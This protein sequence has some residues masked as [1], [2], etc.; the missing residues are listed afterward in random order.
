MSHNFSPTPA[1]DSDIPAIDHLLDL[2]F[3]P[4]RRT[5]TSYRL[6]EGATAADGLSWVVRDD[7]LGVV[8]A[9][10]FWP[11]AIGAKGVPALLLGPLAVHPQRQNLGIGL[12]LM[13][14]ALGLA[15]SLGHK[16]VILVGDA[17][18]YARVGFKTMPRGKLLLPGPFDEARLL[19]LELADGALETAQGLVVAAHR[20]R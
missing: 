6:R 13:N 8:G 4:A 11:L 2:S 1:L 19:Y 10:S 3:G 9:I 12:G 7:E 5:K 17:P 16:L 18:Y 14:H 20:F 15:K